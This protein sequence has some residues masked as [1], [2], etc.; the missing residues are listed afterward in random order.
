VARSKGN[1]AIREN[2]ATVLKLKAEG[3]TQAEV[4]R[5]L[6]LQSRR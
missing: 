2:L 5:A 1:P 3:K 6:G 4:R